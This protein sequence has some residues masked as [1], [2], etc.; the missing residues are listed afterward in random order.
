MKKKKKKKKHWCLVCFQFSMVPLL[1][2]SLFL[3]FPFENYLMSKPL[4]IS[5]GGAMNLMHAFPCI[6]LKFEKI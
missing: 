6:E 3:A 1:N 2:F 4:I 5:I